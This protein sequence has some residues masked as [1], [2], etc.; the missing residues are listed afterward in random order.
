MVARPASL[1][2]AHAFPEKM[3][4]GSFALVSN[5]VRHV[6]TFVFAKLLLETKWKLIS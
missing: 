4:T 6:S 5:P 2:F 1:A 3:Q